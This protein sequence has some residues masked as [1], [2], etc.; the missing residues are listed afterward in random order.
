MRGEIRGLI[1]GFSFDPDNNTGI[2]VSKCD[3]GTRIVTIDFDLDTFYEF[4]IN[5]QGQLI[6]FNIGII[7]EIDFD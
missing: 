5:E 3:G 6:S 4:I 2:D 7:S 1:S